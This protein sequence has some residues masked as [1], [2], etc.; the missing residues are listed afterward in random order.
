[1]QVTRDHYALALVLLAYKQ[2]GWFAPAVHDYHLE[3]SWIRWDHIV[4][5]GWGLKHGIELLGPIIPTL[6]EAVTS[7]STLSVRVCV[8]VIRFHAQ[9]G[10]STFLFIYILGLFL[11]YVQFHSGRPNRQGRDTQEI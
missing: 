10:V 9:G 4:L 1:M 5:D 8:V 7:L 2:M 6:L 11:A 3:R